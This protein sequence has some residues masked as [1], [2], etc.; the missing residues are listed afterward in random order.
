MGDNGSI[1][2][3]LRDKKDVIAGGLI[4]QIGTQSSNLIMDTQINS[5]T[6]EETFSFF[7]DLIYIL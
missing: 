5:Q 7:D 3:Q 2:R 6:K 4:I 1:G